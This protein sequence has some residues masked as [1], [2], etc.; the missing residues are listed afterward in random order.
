MI[1]LLIL[2]LLCAPAMAQ[3]NTHTFSLPQTRNE[4]AQSVPFGTTSRGEFW[5]D[6]YPDVIVASNGTWLLFNSESIPNSGEA[7]FILRTSTNQ[8]ASWQLGGKGLGCTIW[9]SVTPT[10]AH[11]TVAISSGQAAVTLSDGGSGYN[12][13]A[14]SPVCAVTAITGSGATCSV[15]LSGSTVASISTTAGG[16]GYTTGSVCGTNGAGGTALCWCST[17]DQAGCVFSDPV[18]C[19]AVSTTIAGFPYGGMNPATGTVIVCLGVITK[20]SPVGMVYVS[21][22]TDNGA[23][24]SDPVQM[25]VTANA[26]YASIGYDYG[27]MVI[28]PAGQVVEGTT[29]GSSGCIGFNVVDNHCSPAL[30]SGCE[31]IIWSFDDG[32]T[33]GA[34]S[35]VMPNVTHGTIGYEAA[36]A[37]VS[38]TTLIG[39]VRNSEFQSSPIDFITSGDLGHTWTLTQTNFSFDV[40]PSPYCY[41]TWEDRSPWLFNSGLAEGS[42]TLVYGEYLQS[43]CSPVGNPTQEHIR[44]ITFNP[45]TAISNPAGFSQPRDIW[46]SPDGGVDYGYP[47][48]AFVSSSQVK[49]LWE[50]LHNPGF[51]GWANIFSIAGTYQGIP[52]SNVMSGSALL[53]GGSIH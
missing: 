17:T 18:C 8:G 52:P 20:S 42:F 16:S 9:G 34:I 46:A 29:C 32:Q 49:I 30:V 21:R 45:A 41:S 2:L 35:P 3:N 19:T 28:V 51:V 24:W 5:V 1:I 37:Y 53:S 25:A 36:V 40:P 48:V 10:K 14:L 6:A 31:H 12:G 15:T 47:T 4:L 23:N 26:N 27:P 22:S 50:D 44:A 7:E 11:C 13:S 38:G 43:N 33:W 39:F